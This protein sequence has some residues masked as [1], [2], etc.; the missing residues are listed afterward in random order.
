MGC[1]SIYPETFSQGYM[2]CHV[3]Y[4]KQLITRLLE[5]ASEHDK[6][7]ETRLIAMLQEKDG[8]VEV[9]GRNL[10]EMIDRTAM[11]GH[12]NVGL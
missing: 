1:S 11:Q 10:V 6:P 8:F 3:Q 7:L 5:C 12:A 2:L 9:L 4:S